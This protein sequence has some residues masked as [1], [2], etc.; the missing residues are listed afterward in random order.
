MSS[1]CSSPM[2]IKLNQLEEISKNRPVGY[3]EDC[4]S[5]GTIINDYLEITPSNYA[6]LLVKYRG[7]VTHVKAQS[8]CCGNAM[9]PITQ[10]IKNV[11]NA[12]G[13]VVKAVFNNQKIKA[14]DEEIKRR[15]I[16]CNGCEYLN[17]KKC[18][19][20]GC[21]YKIKITLETEHCPEKKW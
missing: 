11:S 4:L 15:E 6:S 18:S 9:P 17:G 16:I 7:I 3:M 5:H 8:S 14:S 1:L 20:C 10:Q 19:R 13:R 12:V 2:K 21:Y